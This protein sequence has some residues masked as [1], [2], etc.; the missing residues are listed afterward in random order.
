M[1]CQVCSGPNGLC[2]DFTD[3]GVTKECSG[4][5]NACS[6][7]QEND[8]FS[9][10]C[11]VKV[12]EKCWTMKRNKQAVLCNCNTDNCNKGNQCDCSS[13]PYN[14]ATAKPI[15]NKPQNPAPQN[16][17]PQSPTPKNPTSSSSSIITVPLSFLVSAFILL[18]IQKM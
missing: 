11:G 2:Q 16:P 15:D 8:D 5:Y 13:D 18:R 1:K 10:M 7:L 3:N 6:F 12:P 9:R 14:R 4:E 17:A